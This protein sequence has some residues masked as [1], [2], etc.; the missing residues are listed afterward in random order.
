MNSSASSP[1]LARPKAIAAAIDGARLRVSTEDGREVSVPLAWFE[2]LAAATEDQR[3]DLR[4]IGGGTGIWWEQLDDGVS[5]PSL[6]GLP[7]YP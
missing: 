6:F 1:S 4:I 7:E 5:V 2:W 3:L